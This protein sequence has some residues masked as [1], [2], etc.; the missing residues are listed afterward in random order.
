MNHHWKI[1]DSGFC[2]P[3]SIMA[4]DEDL[5][6]Q[7]DPY[8]PPILHFYDWNVPCLTYGYFTEPAR[9]LNFDQMR[10]LGL[11]KARRPTGGGII[12]HLSDL[13]FSVLIPAGHPEFSLNTLDNYALINCKLAEVAAHFSCHSLKP[14][15]LSKETTCVNPKCHAF[16]MAKPTQ[17]DLMMNGKKLGG[18]AQ[19]R[20]KNGFLHQASLSLVP[21]PLHLLKG[22][23][24]DEKLVVESMAK[25][26]EYLLPEEVSGQELN[27]IKSEIK[28]TI[29]NTFVF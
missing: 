5:L 6:A 11:K 3:K 25:Y 9:H 23:L 10:V 28:N 17:Y 18:A 29:K 12:F 1:I 7:L 19:R 15:L 22:V 2:A 13:A 14:Q 27:I 8:G 20:T 16:C 24:K 4:K 21:L 26:S